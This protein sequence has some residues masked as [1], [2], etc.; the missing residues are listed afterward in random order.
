MTKRIEYIDALRGFTMILVVFAHVET[1]VLSI[2]PNSTLISELFISFRMPLFFFISGYISYKRGFAW[3][4][5]SYLINLLKKTR[6]QIIPTI[7]FGLS[8]TYLFEKGNICDFVNNY[9]KFGY[10]FTICLWGIFVILY[11]CNF[12]LFNCSKKN[13]EKLSILVLSMIAVVLT[14]FRFLYDKHP[15]VAEIS[16]VFCFHQ[17]CVYYPFFIF[18]YFVSHNKD[19]FHGF[20]DNNIVQFCVPTLFIIAFYY[21]RTLPDSFYL[22]NGGMLLYRSFEYI[23]IGLLGICFVYN[24]FRKNTVFSTDSYCVVLLREVGRRTLDIYMLH[25]FFLSKIPDLGTFLVSST[26]NLTL[27]LLVVSLLSIAVIACCLLISNILRMSKNLSY[28]LFG[29]KVK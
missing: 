16:D 8:F 23:I 14:L 29:V 11:T 24:I 27:E 13:K 28:I 5:S 2:E 26:T 6:I 3:N 10:W 21:K 25:Y 15:L 9:H 4:S 12:I 17:V 19:K 20:L 1:Y 18:G 7:I 22:I